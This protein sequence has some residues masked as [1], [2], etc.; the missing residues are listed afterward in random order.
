MSVVFS[1]VLIRFGCH[2]HTTK[3]TTLM[4]SIADVSQTP[5][6]QY[7]RTRSI[8]AVSADANSPVNVVDGTNETSMS[9]EV[10]TATKIHSAAQPSANVRRIVTPSNSVNKSSPIVSRSQRLGTDH[11]VHGMTPI[12][13]RNLSICTFFTPF[14][15]S[16][17]TPVIP[18]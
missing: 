3:V 11:F 16:W 12:H 7:H 4:I 1:H 15:T 6:A 14:R 5:R 13:P 10:F 9:P 18:T 2:W 17:T 8:P